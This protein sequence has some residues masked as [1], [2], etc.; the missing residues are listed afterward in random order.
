MCKETRERKFTMQNY[1]KN[2]KTIT[3]PS[4]KIKNQKGAPARGRPLGF[5]GSI[6][7]IGFL[8]RRTHR[9]PMLPKTPKNPKI[10]SLLKIGSNL[11]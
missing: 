2:L 6:G 5:I 11:Q 10:P 4:K 9:L 7:F 8:S 3:K 1:E